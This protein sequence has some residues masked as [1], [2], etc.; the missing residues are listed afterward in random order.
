MTLP[1][2]ENVLLHEY[3]DGRLIEVSLPFATEYAVLLKINGSPYVT[4]ACSGNYLAEHVTGYLL[5]EGIISGIDQIEKMEVDEAGLAIN[6]VLVNDR[7]VHEKLERIKTISAAGGRTQK[8]LPSGDLIR[9]DLPEVRAEAILQSMSEFL[10]YSREHEAT[11]G[12]H[13][14]ALYQLTG[15]RIV[16]FDEIGRHNAIDKVI[17]HAAVNGIR[18][19][20]KM[21]CS[22]GRISSEIAFKFINARAPI[23]ITRASP[24]TLSVK[25]L[26]RYNILSIIRAVH[27]RFYIVNGI[28]KI[29]L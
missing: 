11:H 9:K 25:L 26:R 18:L 6:A 19:E 21:I 20:D 28:E 27:G 23:L 15:E 14:A 29:K 5:T 3:R 17:G 24:T 1:A 7:I 8:N 12:V 4:M 13:S 16:F 2:Q 22:T 10:A